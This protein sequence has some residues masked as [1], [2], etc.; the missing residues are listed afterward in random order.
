M[1]LSKK[2][3]DWLDT[4][5]ASRATRSIRLR[6]ATYTFL[7]SI[8]QRCAYS[9]SFRKAYEVLIIVCI[10]CS[11]GKAFSGEQSWRRFRALSAQRLKKFLRLCRLLRLRSRKTTIFCSASSWRRTLINLYYLGSKYFSSAC[12]F[13]PDLLKNSKGVAYIWCWHS[14]WLR[15]FTLT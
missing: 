9:F 7:T 15:E 4:E 2:C 5:T 14:R 8:I 3:T 1:D 12:F 6:W 13:N 11:V 10:G